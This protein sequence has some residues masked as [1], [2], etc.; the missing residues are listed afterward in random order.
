MAKITPLSTSKRKRS[1]SASLVDAT[2][3]ENT[4][5]SVFACTSLG[6]GFGLTSSTLTPLLAQPARA[7]VKTV[8]AHVILYFLFIQLLPLVYP[9]SGVRFQDHRLKRLHFRV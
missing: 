3:V 4:G 2:V 5:T 9:K 1:G 8:S 7:R 6:K